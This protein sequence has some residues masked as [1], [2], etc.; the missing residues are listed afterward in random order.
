MR[1]FGARD[2]TST[3]P[4]EEGRSTERLRF[5]PQEAYGE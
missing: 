4:F 2:G 1:D 3:N 5:P